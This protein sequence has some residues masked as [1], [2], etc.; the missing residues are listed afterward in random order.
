MLTKQERAAIAER[1]RSTYYITNSTLFKALTGEEELI[2]N[3]QVR[4]LC[5]IARVIFDL[6][7]TSNMIELPVDKDGIPFKRGDTVYESD[8]TEH[9]VDG[10]A[11][12]RAN[13]K[14]VSV[15]D[16]I[17]NTRILF[18]TDELT[19]KRPVTIASVRK[20][21]KHVLDK[22]EMTSWSMTKLFDIVEQLEKLGDSDD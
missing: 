10:Y 22:G 15:V 21:L 14:I 3:D 2:E 13:A 17:N 4:E 1:L 12:S 11:F 8:G 18:E 19:H 16:L 6:C 7:D 5:V 20:Q 9:I